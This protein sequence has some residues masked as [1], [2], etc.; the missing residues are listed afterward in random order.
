MKNLQ[1]LLWSLPLLFLTACFVGR[2]SNNEPIDRTAIAQL[3]PGK[4]TSQQ[5]VESLGAPADIVQLGRRSA[6]LY[7][8]SIE[9]NT[10]LLL[11]VVGLYN[12]DT[13][14]D[15]VWVFFDENGL[16][17]HYGSTLAADRAKRAMPWSEIYE[18]Q[19]GGEDA[20]KDSAEAVSEQPAEA[21]AT[22][23]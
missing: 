21:N 2:T 18:D 9:R 19:Q 20:S 13:R 4:T 7:K 11:I 5:V 10:G 16:L 12:E 1:K 3:E 23:E 17:T 14:S 6:Y 8:H 22:S 15:R